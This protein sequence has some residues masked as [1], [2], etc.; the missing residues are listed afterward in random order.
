MFTIP[1]LKTWTLSG[2]IAVLP[3]PGEGVYRSQC[4]NQLSP[5]RDFRSLNGAKD[6]TALVSGP[7]W[8]GARE[9]SLIRSA[10]SLTDSGA[11]DRILLLRA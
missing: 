7:K 11:T 10:V 2:R 8:D 1:S 9:R 3:C 5:I 4:T 6:T